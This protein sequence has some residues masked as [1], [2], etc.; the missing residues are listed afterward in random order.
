MAT[1]TRVGRKPK[2]PDTK[3]WNGRVAARLRELRQRKFKG[4]DEF[5]DALQLRGLDV[6]KT[7]V[8]GWETGYHFPTIDKLPVIAWTLG[9]TVRSLLPKE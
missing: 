2:E 5:V 7:T 8:S 1:V 4:Q 9:V 3:T 6:T